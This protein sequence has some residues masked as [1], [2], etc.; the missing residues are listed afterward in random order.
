MICYLITVD[1]MYVSLHL[2]CDLSWLVSVLESPVPQLPIIL[3]QGSRFFCLHTSG[4]QNLCFKRCPLPRTLTK[5]ACHGFHSRC[6]LRLLITMWLTAR[7]MTGKLPLEIQLFR[8]R[9]RDIYYF[10]FKAWNQY[11][12]TRQ[13]IQINL[14]HAGCPFWH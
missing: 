4:Q 9:M 7:E 2:N 14:N 12:P 13:G 3:P 10:W 6:G 5:T 1:K 8:Q 11:K